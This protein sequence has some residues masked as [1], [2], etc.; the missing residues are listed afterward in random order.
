MP[1]VHGETR[2]RMDTFR[3]SR[4]VISSRVGDEGLSLKDIDVVIEYDF[5]GGSRRQEAQRVGR[6]MHGEG[7]RGEH[8][9]LMTD[10]EYEDH[11]NRL[12]SLEE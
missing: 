7:G 3:E 10:D 12:Y 5:H 9:I 2:D 1:F 4:V 6:V 11:G 8:I